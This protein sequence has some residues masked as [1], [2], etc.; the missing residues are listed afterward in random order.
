[1]YS[2]IT[3]N[4]NNKFFWQEMLMNYVVVNFL[5][6]KQRMKRKKCEVRF[7]Y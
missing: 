1:M 6:L 4:S 2:P 3:S 7:V 5:P